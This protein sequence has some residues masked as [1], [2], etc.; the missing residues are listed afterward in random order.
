MDQQNSLTELLDGIEAELRRLRYLM[1]EPVPHRDIS[2]ASGYGRISFEQ[3]LGHVFLPSARAAV[4]AND[5]PASSQVAGAAVRNLD[6]DEET[7]ALLGLLN[8]FD[9]KVNLLGRATSASR[10]T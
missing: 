5:L 6:G 2:S 4:A 9:S 7:G 3:W 1:G 10:D 8:A